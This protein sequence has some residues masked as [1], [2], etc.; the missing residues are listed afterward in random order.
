MLMKRKI[1][2]IIQLYQQ[3]KKS[4]PHYICPKKMQNFDNKAYTTTR[5]I[6]DPE[7]VQ[8]SAKDNQQ[9]HN[10]QVLNY[11][12]PKYTRNPGYR[13]PNTYPTTHTAER[14]FYDLEGINDGQGAGMNPDV[15]SELTRGNWVN[16][17]SDRLTEKVGF[18][19]HIDIL[20]PVFL[21]EYAHKNF[22][23]STTIS[24]NPQENFNP[25]FYLPGVCTR[26]YQ[27][28][29][30]EYFRTIAHKSNKYRIKMWDKN[31]LPKPKSMV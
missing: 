15:D 10:Y 24:V 20:P 29:A 13:Y 7:Y 11:R 5:S 1:C 14:I 22:L 31:K 27:R 9:I 16:L 19:R 25:E 8:L 17:P 4:I 26:H 23:V 21:P 12:V 3:K 30:D 18:I 2:N 28:P 6:N